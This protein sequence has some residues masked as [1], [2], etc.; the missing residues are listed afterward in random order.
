MKK[1]LTTL[2]TLFIAGC[3]TTTTQPYDSTG[4]NLSAPVG[5]DIKA[6]LRTGRIGISH[7]YWIDAIEYSK[8]VLPVYTCIQQRPHWT[9]GS[10]WM[11]DLKDQELFMENL[12]KVL[13]SN[14]VYNEDSQNKLLVHFISVSQGPGDKAIYNFDVDISF[15]QNNKIV[16]TKN[17]K[18]IGNK[19]SEEFWKMDHGAKGRA[20]NKLM[21]EV[22]TG[23]NE[24]L[25]TLSVP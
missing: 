2:I 19:S 23:T 14:T 21:S 7:S 20:S 22:I 1:F 9:G 6:E 24:W 4:F 17:I 16:S 5:F 18:L 3:T 15:I 11:Y 25:A 12:K 10:Y 8:G 13:I